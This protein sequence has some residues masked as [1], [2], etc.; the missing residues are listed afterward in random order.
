MDEHI[1]YLLRNA[2]LNVVEFSVDRRTKMETF[3]RV[4]PHYVMSYHKKGKAKLRVGDQTYAITPGTVICIPPN[5]KHD[6]YKESSEETVFL[7][8]HFSFQIT[9]VMDVLKMFHLPICFQLQ[10]ADQFEEVFLQFINTSEQAR[11]LPSTIL[12]QAKALEL[13]YLILDSAL[14]KRDLS[15]N[16]FQSETFLSILARMIQFP[17]KH[18]SLESL[19]NE[20]HMHP[21]YI[22]NRFKELFGKTPMQVQREMKIQKAKT[23]LETNGMSITEI[24]YALGFNVL[25]NFTRLFKSYVGISPSQYRDLNKKWREPN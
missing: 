14:V 19:A 16:S 9:N 2:E 20:L 5:V 17:E 21:T 18:I 23:L 11:N 10:N 8:W 15:M 4:L 12:K 25:Q 7:W 3:D 13:L 6:H 24:A 22:S 1:D